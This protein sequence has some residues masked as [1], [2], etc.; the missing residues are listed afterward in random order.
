MR[1]LLIEDDAPLAGAL[2]AFLNARGFV[3]ECAGSLA[4]ARALL[5]AAHWAA[6]L[7]DWQLPDGEGLAL[8]PQLRRL[9]VAPEAYA[10]WQLERVRRNQ[11]KAM[12]AAVKFARTFP[13]KK[14]IITSLYKAVEALEGKEGTVITMA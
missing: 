3:C 7:L 9:A 13:G 6:V 10:E 1:I 2:M 8:L 5:P 11:P 12:L 4:S 14:A